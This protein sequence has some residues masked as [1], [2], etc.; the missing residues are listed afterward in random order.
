MRPHAAPLTVPQK[1]RTERQ[2][3]SSFKLQVRDGREVLAW[4]EVAEGT[5]RFMHVRN[6]KV[7]PDARRRGLATKLYERAAQKACADYGR[8]I[9]SDDIRS[10]GAEG[11]WQKQVSKGRAR[12]VDKSGADYFDP[13]T[14]RIVPGRRWACRLFALPCP[15]PVSLARGRRR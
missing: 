11:F 7:L 4:I 14:D 9:A 2:T 12:C 15:A 5:G 6:L 8:S 1:I 3:P 13:Y 10:A